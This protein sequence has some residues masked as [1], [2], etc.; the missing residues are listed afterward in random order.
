MAKQKRKR[1][2]RTSLGAPEEQHRKRAT[3]FTLEA[4]RATEAARDAGTCRTAFDKLSKAHRA[5][6][7]AIAEAAAMESAPQFVRDALRK[8]NRNLEEVHGMI[9]GRCLRGA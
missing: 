5:H 1:H 2:R 6:G 9:A 7:G 3:A 8:L 4:L